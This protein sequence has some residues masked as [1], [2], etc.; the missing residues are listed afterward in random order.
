MAPLTSFF[1]AAAQILRDPG[2]SGIRGG[3]L[4]SGLCT[5]KQ[6]PGYLLGFN[7][8]GD[9]DDP[10]A[11]T[12]EQDLEC[13][14]RDGRV[15]AY[16][17]EEWGSHAK[18]NAPFQ[19]RVQA[20]AQLLG[21]ELRDLCASNLIFMKSSRAHMRPYPGDAKLCWP[22]HRLIL[23]IVQPKVIVCIGNSSRSAYG[24]LKSG[25][26]PEIVDCKELPFGTAGYGN[27]HLK[28]FSCTLQNRRSL[29]IGLPHFSYYPLDRA[30]YHE[31]AKDWLTRTFT[32][33]N[34]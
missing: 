28:A 17:D 30:P 10:M 5:L 9:A 3:I 23:D 25:L 4:Y 22:V 15:N 13:L 2:F 11:P 7:P 29:V 26:V 19:K 20:L 21:Y 12:L 33:V 27:W 18:G 32:A 31:L 34:V 6:G 14:A 16:L 8:G 1:A 24:F